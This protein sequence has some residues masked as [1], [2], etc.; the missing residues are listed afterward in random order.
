MHF[1]AIKVPFSANKYFFQCML[2]HCFI[3]FTRITE[4]L[5]KNCN[6][7]IKEVFSREQTLLSLQQMVSYGPKFRAG[8]CCS[9]C[10][11]KQ[12]T[13]VLFGAIFFQWIKFTEMKA[14]CSLC[15]L[16]WLSFLCDFVSTIDQD[17]FRYNPEPGKSLAQLA[18]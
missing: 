12:A 9:A 3:H 6:N 16:F 10:H 18:V 8:G 1:G 17:V 11:D 15:L 2:R 13:C 4:N 5:W 14:L 7:L